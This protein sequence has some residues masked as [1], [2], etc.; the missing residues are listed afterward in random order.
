MIHTPERWLSK[1]GLGSRREVQEWISA[2]R[3]TLKGRPV[4]LD[5]PVPSPGST[6]ESLILPPFFLD[7]K[8]L[9]PPPPLLL[10]MNKPRGVLVTRNDPRGRSVIGGIVSA[11]PWGSPR[12][13]S[14]R[15]LGRLD[16]A[17]A[18]LILLTNFP[19]LFGDFLD[20][21]ARVKRTYRV[22]V[23]PPLREREQAAFFSGRG[24]EAPGYGKIEVFPER[25][26]LRSEWIHVCLTEGKNREIRNFLCWYGYQ[27]LHLIRLSFGPFELGKIAPGEIVDFSG[28][29]GEAGVRWVNW[30]RAE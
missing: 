16:Q 22:Q 27:V 23:S 2:G 8:P 20:P 30:T 21:S 10:A 14:I 4:A 28:R 19:E 29:A 24:G 6:P 11:S 3:L 1:A 7:G 13:G 26:S 9:R 5:R 25:R 12:Y 18:G 17:S 15:P